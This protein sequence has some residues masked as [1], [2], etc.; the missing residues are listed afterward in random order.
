MISLLLILSM[1]RG[2][3]KEINFEILRKKMVEE[4]IVQRGIKDSSVINAML[5]VERHLFVPEE[6]KPY[7]YEDTPLP[8]GYGQTISQPYIV[9]LMTELLNLKK[10]DKVL[11][12]GTGS[13]YQA[14]ILSLLADS[15]FTIEI[16]EGLA[17]SAEVRLKKL[18]YK[19][20]FVKCGDG[21]K[22]W[23]EH[24][25]YDK[26]I[27]TCAPE[28]IPQE[29][30]KQLKINGIMVL[31]VGDIYQELKVVKKTEKGIITEDIIP[32]RFVP[33]IKGE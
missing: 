30:L 18:G 21:Y 15:V 2:M 11:E 27:V 19:N 26:I 5:K 33:M 1:E 9:A 31:P 4:Q 23:K 12:I 3:K 14:A 20:V 28:E 8:I 13:G 6:Y 24:S 25:P 10:E 7:A 29:L 17:K 16:V 32:V 22:G